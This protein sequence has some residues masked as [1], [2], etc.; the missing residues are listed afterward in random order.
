MA[1][2]MEFSL[3][4]FIIVSQAP[5]N[6]IGNSEPG[7]EVGGLQSDGCRP[8]RTMLHRLCNHWGVAGAV[9][10]FQEK[11]Q[12]APRDEA[13]AR[14][15]IDHRLLIPLVLNSAVIQAVYAIMRVT[16]S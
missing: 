16:T 5:G 3:T 15:G 4:A 13:G 6:T 7:H 11:S 14:T 10:S 12:P 9:S 8:A 2:R 1:M